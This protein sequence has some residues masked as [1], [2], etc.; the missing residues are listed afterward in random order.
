MNTPENQHPQTPFTSQCSNVS[1]CLW[2]AVKVVGLICTVSNSKTRLLTQQKT[3][4]K[5]ACGGFI[6]TDGPPW[7]LMLHHN[8]AHR[9]VLLSVLLLSGTDSASVMIRP[10]CVWT[11]VI[12]IYSETRHMFTRATT[13]FEV[14]GR[15][16]FSNFTTEDLQEVLA[17]Q[18]S[19]SVSL[20]SLERC[21]Y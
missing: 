9:P 17:S 19:N 6:M 4:Q 5:L 18:E 15:K 21:C 20:I 7:L 10:V 12:I 13:I 16:I 2:L 8:I 3:K 11:G 14:D 1:W